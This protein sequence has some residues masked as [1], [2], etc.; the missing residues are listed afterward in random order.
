MSSEA[1][2]WT[3]PSCERSWILD[4]DD[5]GLSEET[6]RCPACSKP[7][8]GFSPGEI[9]KVRDST[10][11]RDQYGVMD[12]PEQAFLISLEEDANSPARDHSGPYTGNWIVWLFRP[13]SELGLPNADLSWETATLNSMPIDPERRLRL[14]NRIMIG[15]E[16]ESAEVK[17][18]S[19]DEKSALFPDLYPTV[20]RA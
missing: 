3:C 2:W 1:D 13:F 11:P 10:M 15:H 8:T 16:F 20:Q 19:D 14:A 4:E 9:V 17:R 18:L 12:H 5:R 6:W 7:P